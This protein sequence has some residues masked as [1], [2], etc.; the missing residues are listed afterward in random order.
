MPTCSTRP[1][2]AR[3][4][5]TKLKWLKRVKVGDTL[6]V[7]MRVLGARPMASRPQVGLV[8]SQWEALNQRG[9]S[10]LSMLGWGM[11]GRRDGAAG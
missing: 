2:S 1:V 10:V 4:G 7:R 9:E 11:F 3:P 8:R 5:S 6:S